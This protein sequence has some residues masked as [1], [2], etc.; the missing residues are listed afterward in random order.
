M[1]EPF[2][3][4][5]VDADGARAAVASSH[6]EALCA[7]H[8][9]GDPIVPGAYLAG[10]MAEFGGRLLASTGEPRHPVE[11]ERCLFRSPLRLPATVAVV[12]R[13]PVAGR[14]GTH[15]DAEVHAD[16]RCVARGRFRFA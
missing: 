1:T 8:F 7:G 2:V 13:P 6:L 14:R 3:R 15:V 12:V 10:L 11:V 9:P 4:V 16:G 5:V